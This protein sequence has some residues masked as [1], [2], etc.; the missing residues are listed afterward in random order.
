MSY[1]NELRDR[2]QQ[3]EELLGCDRETWTYIRSILGG[4]RLTSRML[5]VLIKREVVSRET[6]LITCWEHDEPPYGTKAVDQYIWRIRKLLAPHGVEVK[7]M[8]GF[9]YYIEKDHKE[10]LKRILYI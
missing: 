6:F 5:G 7:T 1:Y 2:V 4:T 3:L 8:W 9:G 10:K